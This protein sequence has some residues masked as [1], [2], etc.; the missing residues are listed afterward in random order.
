[1]NMELLSMRQEERH[2]VSRK[3]LLIGG[4]VIVLL[5]AAAA[6][7]LA[8]SHAIAATP[9]T[10]TSPAG[11]PSA[12]DSVAIHYV[13][14]HYAG[15]KATSVQKTVADVEHEVPVYGVR[16]QLPTAPCIRPRAA[17]TMPYSR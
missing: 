17:A 9:S 15:K 1:M 4:I 12:A 2:K 5:I 6:G 7:G 3:F 8:V 10:T 14:S 13:D 11:S 16:I